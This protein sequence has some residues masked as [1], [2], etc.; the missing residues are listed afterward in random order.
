MRR[1][2]F[3][4]E[5]KPCEADQ[6]DFEPVQDP[7]HEYALEDGTRLRFRT[8]V[9]SIYRLVDRYNDAG[10]PIYVTTSVNAAVADVPPG[11]MR[12]EKPSKPA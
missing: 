12:P 11:L 2:T 6:M 4:F 8:Q 5:G 3:P 1:V 9:Q 10:E 7:W